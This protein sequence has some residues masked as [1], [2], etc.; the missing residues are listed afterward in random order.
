MQ[1]ER[2]VGVL[3][4]GAGPTG[5][6]TATRFH[7]L[8]FTDWL[9][10]DSQERP[11]GLSRTDTTPEG[12][13]FD[14]GGHVI[15]SHY[16]DFDRLLQDSVGS[17]EDPSCW[18]IHQRE[19]YVRFKDNWVPYPFQNNLC[20]LDPEDQVVAVNGLIDT[21][22]TRSPSLPANFDEWI[23]QSM[24]SGLADMFMR[25]YNFKVW[26]YPTTQLSWSW[27]GERVPEIDVKRC[28]TNILLKKQD[29]SWGPNATFRFPKQG[30]TGHIW[31]R[32]AANLP[33]SN[34]L[35]SA[36]LDRVDFGEHVAF[37]R[38]GDREVRINYKKMV[39]TIPVE[40]L[41]KQELPY[42]GRYLLHSSTNVIGL[43]IRGQNPHDTK[44]W[45]YFPE[46][47]CPFY[48]ATV[49]SNYAE[50]N[51]PCES[52]HLPTLGVAGLW[53]DGQATEASPSSG[54]YWSLMLEVSESA[55]KP[56]ASDS[57]I[58]E[59][60]QG[61]INAGLLSQ[62]DEIVSVHHRRVNHGYPTPSL[63]RDLA[64][65]DAL[66]WLRGRG[67]L[68]RGRFG[69]YKY[70][71]ANQ[72]H[73]V[74]QGFECANMLL[75]GTDEVT[76]PHPGVVNRPGNKVSE[77]SPETK[78][79]QVQLD[80]RLVGQ[81]EFWV[82]DD[83]YTTNVPQLQGRWFANPSEYTSFLNFYSEAACSLN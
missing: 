13:L 63:M 57:I 7:Q 30:G 18:E 44:C 22:G 41:L 32:V 61:C 77:F 16:D 26:A 81:C 62:T 29:V 40:I 10:V 20:S 54:P 42:L 74:A 33:Q 9:L 66:S 49:F 80:E 64:L 15:F 55:Q 36:T 12:F 70:E 31:E 23:L 46:S 19:S 71:V 37:V 73:S 5:L 78:Q 45:L 27:L 53:K 35:F 83:K 52:T 2:Q 56:V 25:P 24:G 28:V 72:D 14:I 17:F 69:A 4:V 58:A 6:A 79:D 82:K 75:L 48:R 59:C 51:V 39:S 21:K 38:Q 67:V 68:S 60:I 3:I 47:N 65:S 76:L 11:G 50:A 1:E 34:L 8:G 43:G